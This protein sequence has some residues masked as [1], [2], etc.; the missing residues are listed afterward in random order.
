MFKPLSR[1][2]LD[3]D[4]PDHTRL[5]ALV[6]QAF[7]PRRSKRMRPRIAELADELIDQLRRRRRRST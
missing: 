2:M 7:S 3:V 1:N 5:R 4:P 6:Q